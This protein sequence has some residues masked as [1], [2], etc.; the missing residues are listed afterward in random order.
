MALCRVVPAPH[1][2]VGETQMGAVV[3][4]KL[5]EC[6]AEKRRLLE[7]TQA[8]CEIFHKVGSRNLH[9]LLRTCI[10]KPERKPPYSPRDGISTI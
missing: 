6:R 3:S 2:Q 10:S 9:R 5:G 1:L 7:V 4:R 8:L